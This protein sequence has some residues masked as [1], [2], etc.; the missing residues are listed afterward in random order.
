[1]RWYE[2]INILNPVLVLKEITRS[3]G[4]ACQEI[5]EPPLSEGKFVQYEKG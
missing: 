5:M 2:D 4:S 3:V 1:M